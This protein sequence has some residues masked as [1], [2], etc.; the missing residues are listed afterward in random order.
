MAFIWADSFNYYNTK[1]QFVNAG[2]VTSYS[3]YSSDTRSHSGRASINPVSSFR[4]YTNTTETS[5]FISFW[6]YCDIA[7]LQND[8]LFFSFRTE[9]VSHELYIM[10]DGRIGWEPYSQP[11]EYSASGVI[12]PQAW[13]HFEMKSTLSDST[14]SGD[15][16]LKIDGDLG[17]DLVG[18]DTKYSTNIE[19]VYITFYDSTNVVWYD[20]LFIWDSGGSAP[21]DLL[22][23]VRVEGLLPDG[24]GTT[25]DW[26]GSDADSTDNYLHV[27]DD[28]PDDDASYIET[29]TATDVDLFTFG[30]IIESTPDSILLVQVRSTANRDDTE[31]RA[32]KHLCRSGGVNYQGDEHLMSV[33]GYTTKFDTWLLNPDTSTAWTETTVNAAEF[34]VELTT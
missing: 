27:D 7:T 2:Y 17:I 23:Q 13:H 22:G 8:S 12:T 28:Y 29:A 21:N 30:D 33:D 16:V 9:S 26:V 14:V 1:T 3:D 10:S 19:H 24:N 15:C 31:T 4:R 32:Y 34:G 18:V 20:E 5:L 25:S 11:T 6:F